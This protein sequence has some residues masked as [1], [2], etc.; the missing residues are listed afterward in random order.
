[1][2]AQAMVMK[3]NLRHL[4]RPIWVREF[5]PRA[6]PCAWARSSLHPSMWP[7]MMKETRRERPHLVGVAWGQAVD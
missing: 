6:R 5:P 3:M 1:M 7:W 4:P 2:T